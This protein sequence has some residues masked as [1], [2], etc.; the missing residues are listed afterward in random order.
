[1]IIDLH[2][3]FAGSNLR[4]GCEL[5]RHIN[6]VSFFCLTFRLVTKVMTRTVSDVSTKTIIIES[7]MML[8]HPHKG[9]KDTDWKKTN[10]MAKL[11]EK[12]II[13]LTMP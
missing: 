10:P 12:L 5:R 4:T 13:A 1:M 6:A 8:D 9:I 7:L 11:I 3:I 2:Q